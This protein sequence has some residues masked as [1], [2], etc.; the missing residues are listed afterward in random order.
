MSHNELGSD[1]LVHLSKVSECT[2]F[3]KHS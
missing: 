2:S 1:T 3:R